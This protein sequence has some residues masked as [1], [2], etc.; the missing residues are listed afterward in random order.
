MRCTPALHGNVYLA[1]A[2]PGNE[3]LAPTLH[4]GMY[5]ALALPGI[6]AYA[7]RV[8][9]LGDSDSET[10]PQLDDLQQCDAPS[11]PPAASATPRRPLFRHLLYTFKIGS[12][13]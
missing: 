11:D 4:G 2:L 13:I 3:H 12:L 5:H 10:I 8:L 9:Q 6:I 7:L 1:L